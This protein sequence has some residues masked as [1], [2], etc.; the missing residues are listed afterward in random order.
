MELA[1]SH[2]MKIEEIV[3][4]LD[5]SDDCTIAF[6]RCNEP[7]LCDAICKEIFE[8]VHSRIHIYNLEMNEESTNLF[9]LLEETT[10]SDS[11]N[12]KLEENKKVAFFVFGLDSA[13][14]KKN[15]SGKS[16]A[17]LLL[18]MMREKFLEIKHPILIHAS[19]VK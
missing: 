9:Q 14:K 17:L 16:E 6:V 3:T 18:N 1:P 12:S 19:S 8:R 5:L 11:Y 4:L 13:V 10:K 2:L 7:V 15:I